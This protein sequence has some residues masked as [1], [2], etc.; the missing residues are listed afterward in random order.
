MFT[1]R[2]R[3]SILN[4]DEFI[5]RKSSIIN[6]LLDVKINNEVNT[7]EEFKLKIIKSIMFNN[8]QLKL[9]N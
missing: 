8:N 5:K 1:S 6:N 3:N 9:E 2:Q 7:F 4:I